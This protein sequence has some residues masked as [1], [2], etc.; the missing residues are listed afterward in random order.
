MA[1]SAPLNLARAA[2]G[3]SK[4]REPGRFQ[5]PHRALLHRRAAQ[6]RHYNWEVTKAYINGDRKVQRNFA[7][8]AAIASGMRAAVEKADWGEVGY[9]LNLRRGQVSLI[10]QGHE[11]ESGR[12]LG[13]LV[14]LYQ[15]AMATV[16]GLS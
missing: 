9:F 7:H 2:C 11:H 6:F 12:R 14:S 16:T 5:S 15:P 10:Y 8:I 1:A 3:E 13:L 4:F